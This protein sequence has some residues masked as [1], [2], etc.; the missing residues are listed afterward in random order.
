MTKGWTAELVKTVLTIR[1]DDNLQL[2][3]GEHTKQAFCK[4]TELNTTPCMGCT[5]PAV[6]LLFG[7]KPPIY[8]DMT[9][10]TEVALQTSF[11]TNNALGDVLIEAVTPSMSERGGCYNEFRR[12]WTL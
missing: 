10:C 1:N 9:V 12:V 2:G 8:I 11:A 3:S 5:V 6:F 7:F 4:G